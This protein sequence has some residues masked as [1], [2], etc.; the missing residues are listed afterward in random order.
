M[1]AKLEVL[2]AFEVFLSCDEDVILA[3]QRIRALAQDV[4][5]GALDQTRIV[6][7]ASELARNVV[8][9]GGQGSVRAE[10]L[11][12]RPGVRLAFADQGPGIADPE[13]ALE[14]GNSTIGSMGLGLSGARRLMDEFAL[15]T[16]P[17]RG[18]TVTVVKWLP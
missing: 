13:R 18:T 7:A 4:G 10:R 16:A 1:S 14:G 9:H 2:A 11:A 8:V 5:F 12:P 6:T 15:D 17:G 3:R